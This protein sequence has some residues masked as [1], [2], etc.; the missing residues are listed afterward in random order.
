MYRKILLAYDG[1]VE[2]RR[3]LR[4]GAALALKCD[5]DVFLFA[6]VDNTSMMT[7]SDGTFAA[8]VDDERE[9]IESLLMEGV[10][11]LQGM[12]F[13]PQYRLGWGPP[14]EQIINLAGEIDADLVVV[15]HRHKGALERWWSG[16]VGGHLLNNLKC[17][18]LIGQNEIADS[19]FSRLV[20]GTD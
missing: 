10:Q 18:L 19:D 13:K 15:G 7:T 16:S 3:A 6:V 11:R 4:E 8:I 12:G 20:E 9:Q 1:S 17:S 2:G 5:A 14:A